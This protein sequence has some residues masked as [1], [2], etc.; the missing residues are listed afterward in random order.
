MEYEVIV[1]IYALGLYGLGQLYDEQGMPSEQE[2]IIVA[3][4]RVHP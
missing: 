4:H 1:E 3:A 2:E